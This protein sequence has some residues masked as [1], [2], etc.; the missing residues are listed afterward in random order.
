LGVL[1]ELEAGRGRGRGLVG[2]ERCCWLLVVGGGEGGGPG[3]GG[4]EN[5]DDGRGFVT[6]GAVVQGERFGRGGEGVRGSCSRRRCGSMVG[7]GIG[8][9]GRVSGCQKRRVGAGATVRQRGGHHGGRYSGARGQLRYR[10]VDPVFDRPRRTTCGPVRDAAVVETTGQR[11]L[12]ETV[13]QLRSIRVRF[14][15]GFPG[16]SGGR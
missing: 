7:E 10:P 14:G 9:A 3:R 2:E 1:G 6:G 13:P 11:P 4:G 15:A 5:G 12:A 8:G 16:V